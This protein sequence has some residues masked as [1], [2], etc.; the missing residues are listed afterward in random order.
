MG[1]LRRETQFMTFMQAKYF[2]LTTL[3]LLSN[4]VFL[5]AQECP[6]ATESVQTALQQHV[7]YLASDQLAGRLTG[8]EGERLAHVYIRDAFREIGLKGP[9]E[10][11]GYLQPFSVNSPA[12]TGADT[13]LQAGGK[14]YQAG[15]DFFPL[16]YSANGS[17]MDVQLIDAGYGISAPELNH[18]DYAA[19]AE[20]EGKVFLMNFS[21][22]DGV[23]PH[24]RYLKYHDLKDRLLLAK[25]K[26]ATAVIVY[27]PDPHLRDPMGDFRKIQSVGLPVIF[28]ANSLNETFQA[29]PELD[30]L[31]VEVREVQRTGNNVVGLIDNGADRTVV[32][33]AHYDHLGMGSEGSLAPDSHDVHNGAD[34]NA[35][36]TAALIELARYLHG[37]SGQQNNYLFVAFSGEEM[38]LLGSKYFAD[39]SPLPVDAMNYMLNMDMVGRLEKDKG[40]GIN[41]TGTSPAWD[42][43]LDE[44]DP[45]F[46]PIKRRGSG[47]GPSDH[48]S[49][50]LKDMP[51]LHFFSGTH[52]DYHKPSD[53]ADKINYEGIS[54]IMCL[55]SQ[56]I[57][58]L[59]AAG[60]LAFTPTKEENNE[61]AP[62]F[63]V[64]LGVMPDYLYDGEGMRID[65]VREGKPAEK[66]GLKK[67]DIVIQMGEVKVR[68]MMGYMQGLSMFNKGDK[69]KVIVKRG[70]RTVKVSV[71][72]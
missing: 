58:Q 2:F 67:G 3:F 20:V 54:Q 68:D 66:A 28:I 7:E 27:N 32:I 10:A 25:E 15:I 69:T 1:K 43:V 56:L 52:E 71:Q 60:E 57:D 29:L 44:V 17:L 35:S 31:T 23:H 19:S 47:I 34:D 72:F 63:T 22:P 18:E 62:R 4:C 37:L 48:T 65:G 70:K 41:G 24:S 42:K 38:G 6:L 16:V 36:G 8:T 33:G 39:H 53:D 26:G 49:F 5:S 61:D 12:E 13:R 55:M 45:G 51:V 14:T 64:T 21:S 46:W 50:Y 40:L 59:N 9:M 30:A 11:G